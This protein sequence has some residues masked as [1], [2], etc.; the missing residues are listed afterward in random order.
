MCGGYFAELFSVQV[1]VT[2]K[3]SDAW[4]GR[5]IDVFT[6][7]REEFR[8]RKT[9]KDD[10]EVDDNERISLDCKLINS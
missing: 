8:C 5:Y 4:R 3:G 1:I 7:G 9:G 10:F 6:V 2:H